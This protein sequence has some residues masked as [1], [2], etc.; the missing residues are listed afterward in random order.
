MLKTLKLLAAGL[1]F[2]AH[3][4]WALPAAINVNTASAEELAAALDGVGM[5][6]AEAIVAYREANG[7]FA[8][9]EELLAVRGIGDHVL[10]K[11]RARITL[12]N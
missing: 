5:A 9:L 4:A 10:E 12:R 1:F 3:L 8:S 7:A 2:A 11:N 6:R